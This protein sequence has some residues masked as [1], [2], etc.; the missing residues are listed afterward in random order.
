MGNLRKPAENPC[1]GQSR[2]HWARPP[3]GHAEKPKFLNQVKCYTE[4][5][6]STWVIFLLFFHILL[7]CKSPGQDRVSLCMCNYRVLWRRTHSELNTVN[8]K[9]TKELPN[10]LTT[11]LVSTAKAGKTIPAPSHRQSSSVCLHSHQVTSIFQAKNLP[12]PLAH[13]LFQIVFI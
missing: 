13:W 5:L 8:N 4:S 3:P 6:F 11:P 2:C 7:T 10:F 1:H 9:N 12:F